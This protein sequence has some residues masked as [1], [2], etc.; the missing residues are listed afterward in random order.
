MREVAVRELIEAGRGETSIHYRDWL[1]LLSDAGYV[2][3]GVDPGAALLTQLTRSPVVR[4]DENPG[5]YRIDWDAP[6]RLRRRLSELE[7]SLAQI[8]TQR[9]VDVD[10]FDDARARRDQLNSDITRTE[11]ELSEALRL[12]GPAHAVALRLA[13][14]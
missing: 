3:G 2:I 7:Q 9:L 11:R 1:D 5:W 10:A 4:R 6:I 14:S 12:L 13:Q 8:A